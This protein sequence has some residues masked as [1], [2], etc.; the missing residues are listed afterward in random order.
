MILTLSHSRDET[1]FDAATLMISFNILSRICHW[2]N[3]QWRVNIIICDQTDFDEYWHLVQSWHLIKS[4][5]FDKSSGHAER[6]YIVGVQQYCLFCF[7]K[8]FEQIP[9]HILDSCCYI[10]WSRI[11]HKWSRISLDN[12]TFADCSI[13]IFCLSTKDF[14]ARI[15]SKSFLTTF[16]S[17]GVVLA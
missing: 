17:M 10:N 9:I 7:P 11:A 2:F 4:C 14:P 13:I 3:L 5:Y 8:L 16:S 15:S 6:Q 1:D 12:S